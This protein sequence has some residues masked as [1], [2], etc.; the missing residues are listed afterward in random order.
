MM[1]KLTLSSGLQVANFSSPHTF[2]FVTGEQLKACAPERSSSLMLRAI[3]E[4]T[5]NP[6]GFVDIALQFKLS[7]EVESALIDAHLDEEVDVIIVPFPVLTA[8][9]DAGMFSLFPKIRTIRSADR[10]TKTIH[11][12]RFCL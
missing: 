1:P 3:E 6:R 2:T 9:K 12:D 7:S 11:T 4:E 10:V 5:V 8:V